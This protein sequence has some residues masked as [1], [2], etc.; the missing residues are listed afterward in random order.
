MRLKIGVMGI[1]NK[2]FPGDLVGVYNQFIH[3]ADSLGKEL[4]FDIISTGKG[5]DNIEEVDHA[6]TLFGEKNIDFL[7]VQ[8]CSFASGKIME[9]IGNSGFV[10]GIWGLPE[11]ESKGLVQ[12][13]S[14]CGLNMFCSIIKTYLKDEPV[15]YKWFYG[16]KE[17]REF[18]ARFSATI[19][20]LKVIKK[21]KNMKIAQ[22]GGIAPGFLNVFSDKRK[23]Q[24]RFGIE[25]NEFDFS[26]IQNLIENEINDESIK[27]IAKE[28]QDE[29]DIVTEDVKDKLESNAI[30]YKSLLKFAAEQKSECLAISC[31][32]QFRKTMGVMPC[33]A[34]GKLTDNGIISACEG[35]IEGA[36]SMYI[37]QNLSE[38]S[39]MIMD[40]TNIH[41]QT[42]SI[43]YWHCGN[44]PISCGR[45]GTVQLTSHF[46]PGSHITCEDDVK[47]GTVYDMI[48]ASGEYTVFR[49]MDDGSK[50]LIISGMMLEDELGVGF[51]GTRGWLSNLKYDHQDLPF[52]D[53]VNTLMSEGIPHH[54]CLVKG[55]VVD[56][57]TEC[58]NRLGVKIISPAKYMNALS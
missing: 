17:D 18:I 11:P 53:F 34:Y 5:L 57:L 43:Q 4:D 8:L 16:K 12:L 29:V 50:C 36:L 39:A 58:M 6:L 56:E 52:W 2:T 48:F 45:K 9:A 27:V 41:P 7:L 30:V 25:I 26:E 44:A 55:N 13:N 46:K 47:V 38:N 1:L 54:H 3:D 19:K 14:L 22:V 10:L 15:K 37:L 51:T 40:F 21:L 28:M 42:G 33:A 32:P 20:S 31:W 49:L 24:S 35:D 23:L